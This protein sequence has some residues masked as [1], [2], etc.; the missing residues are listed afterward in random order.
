MTKER[1]RKFIAKYIEDDYDLNGG[2]PTTVE[3]WHELKDYYGLT[4]KEIEWLGL[5]WLNQYYYEDI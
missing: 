5:G 4:P 1:M 2:S 3:Y